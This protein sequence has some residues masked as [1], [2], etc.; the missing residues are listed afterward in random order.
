MKFETK[1]IGNQ[2]L[3]LDVEGEI[4]EGDWCCA[5]NHAGKGF[6][7]SLNKTPFKTKLW[8][9]ILAA[10][11]R[12]GEL[13]LLPPL[14]SEDDEV[15]RMAEKCREEI[16]RIAHC[17]TNEENNV[18]DTGYI[19]GYKAAKAD[20]MYSLED[21]KKAIEKAQTTAYVKTQ[22][23]SDHSTVKHNFTADEIIQSLSKPK[24]HEFV[25]EM[26]TINQD[27]RFD[28]GQITRPKILNGVMQGQ[29]T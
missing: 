17:C 24:V 6:I 12:I 27:Y 18:F 16:N 9:K 26:E 2:Y 5:D 23:Y 19:L 21:M 28:V 7:Q 25:P 3:L 15:E 10:T 20:K 8:S 4:K 1:I 22:L 11:P 29:W 14:P 13:P